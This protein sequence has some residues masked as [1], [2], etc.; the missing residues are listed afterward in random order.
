[1]IS[2]FL[3]R[4]QQTQPP[5]TTADLS[6]S[7]QNKREAAEIILFESR[8]RRKG[9]AYRHDH[10]KRL[11]IQI[12][13]WT[14]VFWSIFVSQRDLPTASPWFCVAAITGVL[15]LTATSYAILP[16]DWTE[17]P[18]IEDMIRDYYDAG[19]PRNELERS[20]MTN[21]ETS[22]RKNE[23]RLDKIVFAVRAESVASLVSV[24]AL[25]T[26]VTL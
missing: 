4:P 22:F 13:G 16:K 5:T 17:A 18:L 12:F 1:M 26:A 21:L 20:L 9:Q 10:F 8:E 14:L 11:A 19:R 25:V 3:R 24:A 6:E 23:A 2:R 7:D 15:S